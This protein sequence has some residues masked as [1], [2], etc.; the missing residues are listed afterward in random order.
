[1]KEKFDFN[2]EK[3]KKVR[4]KNLTIRFIIYIFGVYLFGL[5]I[6]IY[7]NT[8]VG[9]SQIDITNFA[10]IALIKGIASD[11]SLNSL[12]IYPTVLLVFYLIMLFFVVSLRFTN[13]AINYKKNK[14]KKIFLTA[15]FHSILD[16][17]PTFMWA[18]FVD[19]SELYIPVNA[20]GN[21]PILAKTWIYM[22]GFLIYCAGIAIT[23]FANML[24]G[25]YN[26]LSQELYILTKWNYKLCRII[27]DVILMTIG[28]ITMVI[29]PLFS[30]H[31]KG[32]WFG[33]YF[34]FGTIFMAFISGP[35]IGT[36]LHT[37]KKYIKIPQ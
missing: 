31:A 21:L 2:L 14:D 12:G 7:L 18:Y 26:G 19:L 37:I 20:I 15:L 23:V 28:I 4:W 16:L 29:T 33:K 35:V 24:Y 13:A 32:E 11:G 5:G 9:A 1:M 10:F 3:L 34:G 36:M 25:P 17:I 6:A 22:A 27:M 8:Q 30:W